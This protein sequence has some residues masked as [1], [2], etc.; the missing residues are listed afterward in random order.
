MSPLSHSMTC[1]LASMLITGASEPSWITVEPSS[2]PMPSYASRPPRAA[3]L[4]LLSTH[5]MLQTRP[6]P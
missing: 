5:W 2:K 3:T 4:V 6:L 1:P